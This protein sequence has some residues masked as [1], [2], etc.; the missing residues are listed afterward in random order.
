MS[1]LLSSAAVGC[2]T[3]AEAEE[4]LKEYIS[5]QPWMVTN[6]ALEAAPAQG[7]AGSGAA[8]QLLPR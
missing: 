6:N 1:D 8:D 4:I 5:T 2:R 7:P 3:G